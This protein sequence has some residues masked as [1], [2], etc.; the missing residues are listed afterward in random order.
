EPVQ[1]TAERLG[2]GLRAQLRLRAAARALAG[3][4]PG[5]HAARLA[6]IGWQLL[7]VGVAAA[8]PR[9]ARAQATAPSDSSVAAGADSLAGPIR[10]PP[11][12]VRAWQ[13][14]LVRGDRLEHAS[15]SFAL[16]SAFMITTRNR[17]VAVAST[18][19]LGLAKELWDGRHTVF[20]PVDLAA[21]AVGTGL[22]A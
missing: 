13:M 12:R 5:R 19:A 4:E 8:A 9:A 1:R 16:T 2:P 6:A 11:P 21:D 18:L 22:A 15:L 17:G 10:F 3:H 20:D 7:L 14:G